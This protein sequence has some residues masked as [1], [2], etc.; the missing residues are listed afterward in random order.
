MI[1]QAC[2]EEEA[3]E[4]LTMCTA[5]LKAAEDEPEYYGEKII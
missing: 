5:C 2:Y 3:E 1:C 4:G